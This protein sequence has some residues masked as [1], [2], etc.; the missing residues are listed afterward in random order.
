MQTTKNSMDLEPIA[1]KTQES[2]MATL[3][4][5]HNYQSNGSATES[6]PNQELIS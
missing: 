5:T 6:P 3:Y 2:F 4:N 1:S